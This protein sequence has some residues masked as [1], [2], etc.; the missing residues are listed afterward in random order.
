MNR[1]HRFAIVA[2]AAMLGT[3]LIAPAAIAK[4]PAD[5]LERARSAV[6]TAQ[7]NAKGLAKGHAEA[8]GQEDR[9]RGLERAEKAIADAADRKTARDTAKAAD[10]K[11]GRGLGRGHA[12]DVHDLLAGYS[13]SE[14]LSHGEKV[15]G[16]AH[17]FDKVKADHPGRG[18][19][20]TEKGDDDP[21]DEDE[22]EDDAEDE[23]EDE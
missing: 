9:A 17:A 10:D 7:E 15:S 4:P 3:A 19:G 20:P 2:V 21:A 12:A 14:L 16:L 8:P 6:A 5:K 11:P 23:D 22:D 1:R 13:T 18:N